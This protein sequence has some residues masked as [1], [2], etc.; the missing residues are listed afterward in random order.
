MQHDARGGPSWT[1][2][3]MTGNAGPYENH[4]MGR[5]PVRELR[6]TRV[7]PDYKVQYITLSRVVMYPPRNSIN[8]RGG[9]YDSLNVR[10]EVPA[11]VRNN[12]AWQAH[13]SAETEFLRV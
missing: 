3:E 7:V 9:E 13:G 8:V 10:L 1:F 6:G 11:Q 12:I 2:V 4:V 5:V